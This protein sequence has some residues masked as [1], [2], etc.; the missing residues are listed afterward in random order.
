MV[1][2]RGFGPKGSHG[3]YWLLDTSQH[4]DLPGNLVVGSVHRKPKVGEM[5][6]LRDQDMRIAN[7]RHVKT[8]C[9]RSL[10]IDVCIYQIVQQQPGFK[11]ISMSI[12]PL[13]AESVDIALLTSH[14]TATH[15]G[16]EHTLCRGRIISRPSSNE[17][18]A[19]IEQPDLVVVGVSGSPVLSKNGVVGILHSS[20]DAQPS[21]KS[22]ADIKAAWEGHANA[23]F[24]ATEAGVL[25]EMLGR[26][27]KSRLTYDDPSIIT[28][29]QAT[30]LLG[31]LGR[32]D[33][34]PNYAPFADWFAH[35][36]QRVA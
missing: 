13:S 25:R 2:A 5:L 22:K 20:G 19:V 12:D 3:T 33:N 9:R 14:A 31:L 30:Y 4:T 32:R 17:F 16:A 29:Q 36:T 1:L 35:M 34:D 24:I 21:K 6:L 23:H 15:Q 8:V 11:M 10:G 27:D 26:L 18:K 28:H 7:A